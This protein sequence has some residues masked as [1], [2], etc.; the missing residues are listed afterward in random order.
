MQH[1][2]PQSEFRFGSS[3]TG[4]DVTEAEEEEMRAAQEL[5]WSLDGFRPANA[6]FDVSSQPNLPE[7]G[8]VRRTLSQMP[9]DEVDPEKEERSNDSTSAKSGDESAQEDADTEL[10]AEIA[11][12]YDE[13]AQGGAGGP[14]CD[15][16]LVELHP[17]PESV[18]V[19]SPRSTTTH[20]AVAAK[21]LE[22]ANRASTKHRDAQFVPY[23]HWTDDALHLH[24]HREQQEFLSASSNTHGGAHAPGSN[25]AVLRYYDVQGSNHMRPH[26]RSDPQSTEV[27]HL[28][29][30]VMC[31]MAGHHVTT[32]GIYDREHR[33]VLLKKE[34]ALS[35]TSFIVSHDGKYVAVAE[36]LPESPRVTVFRGDA[37]SEVVALS[38]QY[39]SKG[40]VHCMCMSSN[41]KFL[42][43]YSGH[44]T[45][46]PK[47]VLW[48]LDDKRVLASVDIA[49]SALEGR[50]I[51]RLSFNPWASNMCCVQQ[52][53]QITMWSTSDEQGRFRVTHTL[54][55]QEARKK[56][57][58]LNDAMW[59]EVLSANSETPSM[60][61]RLKST[62]SA[63]A[64]NAC[65]GP[66]TAT[67]VLPSMVATSSS[68]LGTGEGSPVNVADVIP[69]DSFS[70]HCWC[71]EDLLACVTGDGCVVTMTDLGAVQSL[72]RI[73]IPFH[74]LNAAVLSCAE[75]ERSTHAA[76]QTLSRVT[77]VVGEVTRSAS[78]LA[79]VR[80]RSL[81]SYFDH[82]VWASRGLLI[83][84]PSGF[85]ILLDR[86]YDERGF[87]QVALL[88]C[89][90]SGPSVSIVSMSVSPAEENL[91][92]TLSNN[93]AE[94]ALLSTF[95]DTL[96]AFVDDVKEKED[97][98]ESSL[99]SRSGRRRFETST[100]SR[101]L[102]DDAERVIGPETRMLMKKARTHA[103]TR[104][105]AGKLTDAAQPPSH[106][107]KRESYEELETP[108]TFGPTDGGRAAGLLLKSS[109]VIFEALPHVSH[110][111]DTVTCVSVAKQLP[112]VVTC[113]L[114]R[115]LR[116]FNFSTRSVVAQRVYDEEV[117]S[118]TIHPSGLFVVITL[119]FFAKCYAI[120]PEQQQFFKVCDL[121][122]RGCHEVVYSSSGGRLA[123]AVGNKVQLYD[124]QRFCHQGTLVGHTVMIKSI[125]WSNHDSR[126][127]TADMIGTVCCWNTSTYLRDGLDASQ[128]SLVIQCARYHEGTGLMAAIGSNKHASGSVFEGEFTI[129]CANPHNAHG[130]VLLRPGIVLPKAM[131][132]RKLHT[133]LI[134]F[135]SVSQTLFVGTPSGRIL[136]YSWPPVRGSKPYDY[137]DAHACEVLHLLLSPDERFLFSV[138]SDNTMFTFHLEQVKGGKYIGATAFNHHMYDCLVFGLRSTLEAYTRDAGALRMLAAESRDQHAVL[139]QSI[140]EAESES[141]VALRKERNAEAENL[142]RRL[143]VVKAEKAVVDKQAIQEGHAV[144]A[145]YNSAAESLENLYAKLQE[146]TAMR[147]QQL[148]FEKDEVTIRFEATVSKKLSQNQREIQ[149]LENTRALREHVLM[150]EIK[151]LEVQDKK[152]S[153]T[154]DAVVCQTVVD[155]EH[156]LADVQ[157]GHKTALRK[158]DELVM[159]AMLAA[160]VGDREVDRLKK[161]IGVIQTQ[162]DGRKHTIRDLQ[163]LLEK[164][165]KETLDLKHGMTKKQEAINVAER[166]MQQMKHQLTAL[167][168]LRFVLTHQYET[169]ES[170][171]QPKDDRIAEL[172]GDVVQLE[173]DLLVADEDR[174]ALRVRSLELKD[175]VHNL[176]VDRQALFKQ[177]MN[178]TRMLDKALNDLST[179]VASFRDPLQF[180]VHLRQLVDTLTNG[181]PVKGRGKPTKPPGLG[182]PQRKASVGQASR[183]SSLRTKVAGSSETEALGRELSEIKD[184]MALSTKFAAQLPKKQQETMALCNAQMIEENS[185]LIKEAKSLRTEKSALQSQLSSHENALRDVRAALHRLAMKNRILMLTEGPD[186]DHGIAPP[187]SL[188]EGRD[189]LELTE[190]PVP[191]ATP[192][193]LPDAPTPA[194]QPRRVKPGSSIGRHALPPIASRATAS[195]SPQLRSVSAEPPLKTWGGQPLKRKPS[196]AERAKLEQRAQ[197]EQLLQQLDGGA[198]K[199]REHKHSIQEL[200]R[201][202]QDL[203]HMEEQRLLQELADTAL[204]V[205]PSAPLNE[206]AVGN[207]T[208]AALVEE[209]DWVVRRS[210]SEAKGESTADAARPMTPVSKPSD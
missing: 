104:K 48:Q 132:S 25:Y 30:D 196:S 88:P 202:A 147:Y 146:E 168:N 209:P 156:E 128:N 126:I 172:D 201:I 27:F 130:L 65:R 143:E 7:G 179:V 82:V 75:S 52:G 84:G 152:N 115:L 12:S 103:S 70:A 42:I 110:H 9:K 203:L 177:S 206:S 180:N 10:H 20:Q 54:N 200:R 47:I 94:V 171:V 184:R 208:S 116:V 16:A 205:S 39:I 14:C 197:L 159:R 60:A 64:L 15:A 56:F 121:D 74:I 76:A 105:H 55:I 162:L 149:E 193:P 191:M 119:E 158:N 32:V 186:S 131:S 153:V 6:V 161:E 199:M 167:E 71:D 46:E 66:N 22:E 135:A 138:G 139:M 176:E 120:F 142:R 58:G 78:K 112:F 204:G 2:R 40:A 190:T 72:T 91:I 136:M 124:A 68:L 97:S 83:S 101:S 173:K 109:G 86:T 118:C 188:L 111:R 79:D 45:Q 155:Y 5:A 95:D 125:S 89:L 100:R 44:A 154:V 157:R 23:N 102:L 137:V 163:V 17:V 140:A 67:G 129:V 181:S 87:Q 43:A 41:N 106:G 189:M 73:Y 148:E 19:S 117:L 61:T 90:G 133:Q 122:V 166:K 114:D 141:L 1:T 29:E 33:H 77:S 174:T 195:P 36:R 99:A 175:V 37:F 81:R 107:A 207:T 187:S 170:D 28:D 13:D 127:T 57:G 194:T 35:I 63:A 26:R 49:G 31:Y 98:M 62:L 21:T 59:N 192:S 185:S 134:A 34:D 85:V 145:S 92:V 18:A 96:N 113:G 150:E 4:H 11:G 182:S 178:A 108:A 183:A 93:T 210:A 3:V 53:R 151:K 50:S 8:G 160:S 38:F 144:E 164:R 198:S 165:S 24:R 80:D 123:F 169:L 69:Y 51:D